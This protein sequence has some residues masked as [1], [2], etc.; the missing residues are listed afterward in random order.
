MP[1]S[2]A[3][4]T[5]ALAAQTSLTKSSDMSAK[6]MS[7][8]ATGNRLSRASD[9]PAEGAI[10]AAIKSTISVLSQASR[11]SSQGASLI[12][13]GA[14]ALKNQSNAL[15]RMKTLTAQVIN[16]SLSESDKMMAR[17]EFLKIKQ[18]VGDISK[19]TRWNGVPLLDGGAGSASF[20]KSGISVSGSTATTN[21]FTTLAAANLTGSINGKVSSISVSDLNGGASGVGAVLSEGSINVVFEN[22]EVF[23][24]QQAVTTSVSGKF[25]LT[26]SSNPSNTIAVTFNTSVS[27]LTSAA[28]FQ[29]DLETLFQGATFSGTTAQSTATTGVSG[30]TTV[31]GVFTGVALSANSEI[32]GSVTGI[33]VT[34]TAAT[35]NGATSHGA[36]AVTLSNGRTYSNSAFSTGTAGTLVLTD[37]N[38][39]D[40]ITLTVE[41]TDVTSNT[42]LLTDLQTAI[43][44]AQFGGT[45]GNGINTDSTNNSNFTSVVN[46]SSGF[47]SGSVTSATV[48]ADG[49]KYAVSVSVGNQTYTSTVSAPTNSGVLTLTSTTDS[50]N[51]LILNYDTKAAT[52]MTNAA[53]FQAGLQSFLGLTGSTP[54]SFSSNSAGTGGTSGFD[55]I[56]AGPTAQAGQYAV[57]YKPDSSNPTKGVMKLTDGINVY[58]KEITNSGKQSIEF[59][60]GISIEL[61][62][63][64]LVSISKS[65]IIFNVS[66]GNQVDFNFQVAE[67][68]N[69][70]LTI[71][72]AGASL[73]ALGLTNVDINTEA[74]AILASTALDSALSSVN[75]SYASLGAQQKQFEVHKELIA[76]NMQNL[77]SAI[78]EFIDTDVPEAITRMGQASVQ[79]QIASA[80]LVQAN[81]KTE[82]LLALTR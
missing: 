11:N 36:V 43:G 16:G 9:A 18:L 65:Q 17:E 76:S 80:M 22:G 34:G 41:A 15:T 12:Q 57:S 3:T 8:L 1:V 51:Q 70:I 30:N 73:D 44:S 48:V 59:S 40:A 20:A 38:S 45:K 62:S 32:N 37:T 7:D 25:T 35:A 4:N 53:T 33:T 24:N 27:D 49:Q 74:A 2:S 64:F 31:T 68:A 61:G 46:G 69:D 14:D 78:S 82:Q 39:T 66:A 5:S 52:Y 28:K 23:T 42:T 13:V 6:A 54:A 75:L 29:T 55:G 58:S 63:S 71:N 47:I 50:E 81:Q 79:F 10:G 72:F 67:Q 77:Q 21:G 56:N 26:S 19:Q 60:N